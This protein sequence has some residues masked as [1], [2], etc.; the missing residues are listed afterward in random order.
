[1]VQPWIA[2]TNLHVLTRPQET[3][4]ARH[5]ESIAQGP[6]AETQGKTQFHQRAWD[7]T[8]HPGY[9]STPQLDPSEAQKKAAGAKDQVTL[10]DQEIRA[11]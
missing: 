8:G 2:A 5:Q 4:D 1:M 7:D 9:R 11:P 3:F 10:G 6:I